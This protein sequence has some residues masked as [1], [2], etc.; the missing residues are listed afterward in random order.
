MPDGTYPSYNLVKG[1]LECIDTL[2][3]DTKSLESS[4]LYTIIQK[5]ADGKT[6]VPQV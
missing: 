4:N 1:V 3:L 5:Y 6:G 2:S